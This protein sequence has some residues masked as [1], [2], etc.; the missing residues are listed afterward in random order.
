VPIV[1]IDTETVD[2]RHV[3]EWIDLLIDQ[4]RREAEERTARL[5]EIYEKPAL[6]RCRRWVDA[7]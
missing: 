5:A 3:R 6:G 1:E 7:T 4:E 2:L